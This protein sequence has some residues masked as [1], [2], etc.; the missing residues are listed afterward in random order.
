MNM[1]IWQKKMTTN[2]TH[3]I[4]F[5]SPHSMSFDNFDNI[6]VCM[7]LNYCLFAMYYM[8]QVSRRYKAQKI[9]RTEMVCCN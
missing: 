7:H 5:Y 1:L 9:S 6:S 3:F 8:Y 4:Q 2:V